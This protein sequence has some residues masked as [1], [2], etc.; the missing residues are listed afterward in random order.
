[1]AVAAWF[2]RSV[3]ASDESLAEHDKKYHPNGFKP[4]KDSC[5]RRE[6]SSKADKADQL[7]VP[8]MQYKIKPYH[9]ST[10]TVKSVKDLGGGDYEVQFDDLLAAWSKKD[11]EKDA[12]RLNTKGDVPSGSPKQNV[13]TH[14]DNGPWVGAELFY[15]GDPISDW[16]FD[17][18]TGRSDIGGKDENGN[19]VR[20][21]VD[22]ELLTW[23]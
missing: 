15:D 6:K 18:E 22:D 12:I 20:L 11:L 16:S 8:G 9:N 4:G 2:Q 14:D 17:E 19:K 7:P 5:G 3:I 23:K 13:G 21:G 1:M 10:H